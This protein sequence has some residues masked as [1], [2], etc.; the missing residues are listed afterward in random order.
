MSS[1]STDSR[2]VPHPARPRGEDDHPIGT[3]HRFVHAV[4]TD[5]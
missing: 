3:I 2:A 5:L 4:V 1:I